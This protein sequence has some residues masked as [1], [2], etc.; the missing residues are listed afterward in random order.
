M[1]S[2][3]CDR[4]FV[5][6]TLLLGLILP[7]GRTSAQQP[8]V[9]IPR[10]DQP[11]AIDGMIDEAEWADAALI[12][13]LIQ[14][15]SSLLT[16][17]PGAI[18]LK[19][20]D[21]KLYLGFRC[22]LPPGTVPSRRF[23]RRD[24]PVYMD[25]HQIELWLTPPVDDAKTWAYQFIGNAYGAIFDNLQ[26][27]ELG[28]TSTGW[29]GDWEFKNRF[30]VGKFW[31]AELS[32]SA[33][34]LNMPQG[35]QPGQEW[36]GMVGIAWPQRSWPFTGGWYKNV[37]QHARWIMGGDAASVQVRGVDRLLENQLDLELG[38]RGGSQGGRYTAAVEVDG[39]KLDGNV[40][41]NAKDRQPIRLNKTL[42]AA[43][44]D[45]RLLKLNVRGPGGKTLFEGEWKFK[46]GVEAKTRKPGEKEKPFPAEVNYAAE[47]KAIRYW[48]DVLDYRQRSRLA[49]CRV[50]VV[51]K[52]QPSRRIAEASVTEFNYD[53][54]EGY[55]WL[56]SGTP[57]GEYDVRFEF[58]DEGGHVLDTNQKTFSVI[59]LKQKF[60]WWNNRVGEKFTVKP[61]FEPIRVAGTRVSV[62]GRT[63]QFEG[64]PF[65]TGITSQDK[66]LLARPIALRIVT[67]NGTDECKPQ[68]SV[69]IKQVDETKVAFEGE[70][71]TDEV[72]VRAQGVLEFD[73][74]ILYS[75][76]LRPRRAGVEVKRVYLSM[77]MKPEHAQ[78]Y[79]TSAGGWSGAIDFVAPDASDKPFWTSE[80][81]A[82]FI[83]Y[84]GFSD[85][86]RALQWFADNDH[87][88]ILGDE[89]PC[90][91]L[92][93]HTGEVELQ[94]NLVRRAGP[95]PEM[96][97]VEMGFIAT[98]VKAL[99]SG[100]RNPSLHFGRLCDAKIAFFYG[101]GHGGG[102]GLH[103]TAGLLKQLNVEVP[104]GQSPDL[105]LE[106]LS[107]DVQSRVDKLSSEPGGVV[108]CPFQ[109][110]QMLFEGYRSEAFQVLFPGDWR[111]Y[112]PGGWFHLAPTESYRDFFTWHFD[113]WVKHLSVRGVYF[114]EV[115]FPMD[116]NVFNGSGKI[117][118]EGTVRPSCNLLM[119]RAFMRRVRQVFIDRG[120]EPFVWVHSSNFMAPHAISWC[121][122]A[123]FGEDR[124]PTAT[125][126][127]IDNAPASHFRAIGRSQKFGIPP[128]WMNQV[129]RGGGTAK[130]PLHRMARQ[131]CG[132]CWMF[133][134]GVELHSI[135]RGRP[136]QWQRVHWGLMQDQVRYHPYWTQKLAEA[137]DK[138]VIISVWT[139][140]GSALLQ[141][142]N[143]AHSPKTVQLKLDSGA[144][145]LGSAAKVYDLESTPELLNLKQQLAAF[146][147]GRVADDGPVRELMK[148]C[149]T[150]GQKPYEL[151]QLK[152]VGNATTARIA[153]GPR[154][155]A[156]LVAQ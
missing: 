80:K 22:T 132:W 126:D 27:P 17:P 48:A 63:Y 123:M 137:A 102:L 100:W 105:V 26:H 9:L 143:L 83:P 120:V 146:D 50:T 135:V 67:E 139:R 2:L 92:W 37:P 99:P 119:Q 32:I 69:R 21:E 125:V 6:S 90:A 144:L 13:G 20:D 31:E 54:A 24:E 75:L 107:A 87:N 154:D 3:T 39:V 73:G 103:D 34:E 66:Q 70:C 148:L 114:D 40:Q 18:Y 111:I 112:P 8:T 15:Q 4:S 136:Q 141:I 142:F 88:W 117:L 101:M 85:D 16:P 93:R 110:A 86:D 89:A 91:E 131:T 56:P 45:P 33:R 76:S 147:A 82:P 115:Y 74:M 108:N 133:D 97:N 46:P 155:F 84:V 25:T 57:T 5:L 65:P 121:Q 55:L 38:I 14:P 68:G 95:L 12:T 43:P 152:I 118:A 78:Y 71:G 49:A 79:H 51:P 127:F 53:Q 42:P 72:E 96:H 52:G 36:R 29:N 47:A 28:S 10:T 62:W 150:A 81:F 35:I 106:R 153:V 138:D 59:D 77:A 151:S 129:G 19:H 149:D 61:E 122:M 60:H 1:V 124:G 156:L 94:V 128:I 41:L 11:P 44:Q 145:R 64:G 7:A 30:E 23:R 134:T 98:P 113:K 116:S 140:P 58:I 130:G 109:N 104:Q